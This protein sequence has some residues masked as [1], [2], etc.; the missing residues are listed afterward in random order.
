MKVGKYGASGLTMV[1]M[2][3]YAVFCREFP[4]YPEGLNHL[5]YIK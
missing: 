5:Y 2:L 3:F 4:L 1:P